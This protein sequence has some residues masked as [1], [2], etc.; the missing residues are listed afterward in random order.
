MGRNP[1][2]IINKAQIILIKG[3]FLMW[4][5][6]RLWNLWRRMRWRIQLVFAHWHPP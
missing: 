3:M 6:L 2:K 1:I 4:I 5:V